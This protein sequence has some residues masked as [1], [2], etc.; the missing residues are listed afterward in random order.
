MCVCVLGG[1]EGGGGNNDNHIE[2]RSSRFFLNNLIALRTV[3][4]TYAQVA[5]AQPCENNVQHIGRSSHATC[6]VQRGKR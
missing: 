4:N 2:W 5:K 3:S 6:S 1:G